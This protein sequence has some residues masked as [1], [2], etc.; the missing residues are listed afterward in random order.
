MNVLALCVI[1][2]QVL[3]Q[4][5]TEPPGTRVFDCTNAGCHSEV[6]QA[7]YLH[8]PVASG[9]CTTCHEYDSPEEHT[10]APKRDG[11]QMCA[12]CHIG[13]TSTA[14]LLVHV[15][16]A[17][18]KCLECHDPH[19]SNTRV[20]L[21]AASVVENCLACHADFP[22]SEGAI[23]HTPVKE[24]DCMSCHRAHSSMRPSLLIDE[25]RSLCLSCHDD[26]GVHAPRIPDPLP[27]PHP[28][29]GLVAAARAVWSALDPEPVVHNGGV[30]DCAQCHHHHASD[31]LSLLVE[32]IVPLCSSCHQTVLDAAVSASVEHP[33]V[34]D[35]RACMICHTPHASRVAGLLRNV[36]IQ[37]CASCHDDGPA[38]HK[39]ETRSEWMTLAASPDSVVHGRLRDNCTGCHDVHGGRH[40][41]LLVRPYTTDFYQPYE[42][43]AYALCFG[44]HDNDMIEVEVTETATNFRNG[45]G[46]LHFAHVKRPG[47]K[48]R[49]CRACHTAHVSS[50]ARLIRAEVP[51]GEWTVPIVFERTETGGSCAAGCHRQSR[52]D[53]LNPVSSGERIFE[54]PGDP[55]AAGARRRDPGGG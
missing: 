39:T 30:G 18:G 27:G 51:F 38:S 55:P 20:L 50:S 37:L 41:S 10:F 48:G 35:D 34:T 52:Y 6:T 44:C 32:P 28:V 8:G 15:P 31:Q 25:G 24:G 11:A 19:G 3:A 4:P 40:A 22:G 26:L 36:P 1:I 23:P 29:F 43:R 53:R 46:N 17:E 13:K 12:F 2:G 21:S 7:A 9:A 5:A 14:G 33:G 47:V 54:T 49:S 42:R 16:V 45:D